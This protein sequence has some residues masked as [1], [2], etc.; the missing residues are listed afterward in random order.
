MVGVGELKLPGENPTVRGGGLT[1]EDEMNLDG[2][3][4][5]ACFDDTMDMVRQWHSQDNFDGNHD[6]YY[7]KTVL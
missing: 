5:A 2:I 6:P 4:T 1:M 7:C 3:I